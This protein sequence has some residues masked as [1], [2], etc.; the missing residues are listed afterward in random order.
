M[1]GRKTGGRIKGTPNKASLEIKGLARRH[2]PEAMRELARLATKADSEQ[3]RIAAIKEIL[4]RGYGKPGVM[5]DEPGEA[6]QELAPHMH[7]EPLFKPDPDKRI[8]ERPVRLSDWR[9]L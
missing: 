9:T 3:A 4:D 8:H 5:T 7:L 1:K 2:A 6:V